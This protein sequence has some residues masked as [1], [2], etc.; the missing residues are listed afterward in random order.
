MSVAYLSLINS[1]QILEDGVFNADPHAGNVMLCDDGRL[2][3]IDYGNTPTLTPEERID[4]ARLIVALDESDDDAVVEIFEKL[5]YT[6]H[7]AKGREL[8]NEERAFARKL[9]LMSAY[10]DFDQQYG[11]QFFNDH[12]GLPRDSSVMDC[13]KHIGEDIKKFKL[14]VVTPAN[15]INL[16]RCVM[17]LNGVATVTGAG[18]VRPSTMWRKQ[19]DAL[20]SRKGLA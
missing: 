16:Q 19:A 10:G 8:S 7:G 20:L 9:L 12:F 2:G 3:L 6:I 5:G 1:H 17:T 13:A 18:N 11:T 14:E 15:V 4:I